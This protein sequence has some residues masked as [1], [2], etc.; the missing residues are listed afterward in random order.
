MTAAAVTGTDL[1]PS[2]LIMKLTLLL[3]SPCPPPPDLVHRHHWT[4]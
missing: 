4:H 3:F 2:P 1:S